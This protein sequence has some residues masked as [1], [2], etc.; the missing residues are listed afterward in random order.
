M[1]ETVDAERRRVVLT[2]EAWRHIFQRH[3]ELERFRSAIL[4]AVSDPDRRIRGPE[5]DEEWFYRHGI[6]PSLWVKVAVHYEGREGRIVTAFPR[7][8]FP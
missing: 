6:G 7:R 4:E 5:P 2:F 1:W 3:G 8:R